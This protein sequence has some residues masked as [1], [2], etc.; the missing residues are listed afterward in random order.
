LGEEVRYLQLLQ[1]VPTALAEQAEAV[2][3]GSRDYQELSLSRSGP[4]KLFRI[5]LTVTLLLTILS[6]IAAS[7]PLA[8]WV[9][10]PPA[11]LAAGTR[12]VAEGDFRPVK[13]YSGRDELGL[14]MQSFNAM[15][16]QLDEARALVGRKQ[17]ELE[18]ANARL[19]SV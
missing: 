14:L 7:F 10:G 6:A 12:A 19:A 13:D 16:R 17:Q 3:Q 11:M 2:Q 8:G 9:P 5:T 4:K 15:T 18:H 1:P